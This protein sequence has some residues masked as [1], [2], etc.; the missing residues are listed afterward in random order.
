ML[1]SLHFKTKTTMSRTRDLMYKNVD[2]YRFSECHG[3]WRL[4]VV[5]FSLMFGVML[6]SL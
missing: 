6:S 4:F 1:F 5:M 2:A 3:N